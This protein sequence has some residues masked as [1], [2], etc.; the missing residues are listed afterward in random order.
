MDPIP[1]ENRYFIPGEDQNF[2]PDE[3]RDSV[4]A[5]LLTS[6]F[7]SCFQTTSRALIQNPGV[8]GSVLYMFLTRTYNS[9]LSLID[10]SLIIFIQPFLL[11]LGLEAVIFTYRC[12]IGGRFMCPIGLYYIDN[13][14][15]VLFFLGVLDFPRCTM[16]FVLAILGLYI[17]M[18]LIRFD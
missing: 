17:H 1:D 11:R 5:Q 18:R 12:I 16:C 3:D 15:V 9:D 8:I 14:D 13:S 10:L 6:I 7:F 4:F 2:I